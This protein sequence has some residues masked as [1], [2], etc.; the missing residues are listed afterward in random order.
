VDWGPSQVK[1]F[2]AL[3]RMKLRECYGALR[4]LVGEID[5]DG[6]DELGIE[7]EELPLV[8]GEACPECG[9]PLTSRWLSREALYGSVMAED[10]LGGCRKTQEFIALVVSCL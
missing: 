6:E 4:G 2:N 10:A 8:E 3:G 7:P 5:G 1:Q 9:L